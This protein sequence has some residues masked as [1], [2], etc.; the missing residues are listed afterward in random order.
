M[1]FSRQEYWSGLSFPSPGDLPDPGIEP[2]SPT[3]QADALP[4]KPP[5]KSEMVRQHHQ[6]NG[7]EFEQA[8]GDG[9]G[10]GSLAYC[11]PWGRKELDTTEWPN[12]NKALP[13]PSLNRL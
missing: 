9:E 5:G 1:G 8:P 6:F 12:N 4:S 11:S 2:Q 3:L 10:Q 13:V 7:H